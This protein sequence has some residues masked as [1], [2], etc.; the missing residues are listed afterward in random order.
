[1]YVS[2]FFLLKHRKK[3]DHVFFLYMLK[4]YLKEHKRLIRLTFF[5]GDGQGPGKLG[6]KLE[7]KDTSW[8]KYLC[9]FLS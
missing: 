2:L 4:V 1:M 8:C 7:K 9:D 5:D 3:G 6:T